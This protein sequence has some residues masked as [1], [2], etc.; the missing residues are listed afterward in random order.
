MLLLCP[1]SSGTTTMQKQ[2]KLNNNGFEI[3]QDIIDDFT[4]YV[5]T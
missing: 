1:G 4:P 2:F 3:D 5:L